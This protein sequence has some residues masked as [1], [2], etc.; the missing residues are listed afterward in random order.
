MKYIYGTAGFRADASLLYAAIIGST[1]AAALRSME[2]EGKTVGVI[3]T[4]SHN[5]VSD[6]GVK[7]IDA[8]GGMLSMAWEE[9]CTNL[10]NVSSK[11]ELDILIKEYLV[12]STCQASVVIGMD[13]R[14]SSPRLSELSK[15]ILDELS[16]S[17]KDYG[18]VTT[19]Q[20]HWIV[21]LINQNSTYSIPSN[22]PPL[23]LYYDSLC[24]AY[25]NIFSSFTVHHRPTLTVDCAN[26][27]GSLPLKE[28]SK[29]LRDCIDLRLTNNDHLAS[30]YLNKDCGADYV[31]TT[32][33]PP[34][35]LLDKMVPNQLYASIDGDADRIIFYFVDKNKKFH[36]LD[37]D[38]ISI[39]LVSFLKILVQK[40][41]L[42]LSI[43]VIQTAY[44]NG[45]STAY[46]KKLGIP[47]ICTSTG[48]K[49]LHHAAKNFDI[50]VYFEANGH[51][52]VLFS[53]GCLHKLHNPST[54]QSNTETAAIDALLQLSQL[55]NQ[56]I[57]DALSDMLAVLSVLG[58][59]LWDATGWLSMYD[60]LPN[61]LVKVKV[62]D[63][64]VFVTTDAERRL[65]KPVGLQEKIDNLVASY[66]DSRSF[67]RA[68]GTEDAVRVYAEAKTPKS[69]AELSA[70]VCGLLQ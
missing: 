69:A 64:S 3:I 13:T 70:K 10:A 51:G 47:I 2:L 25:I 54:E 4:A 16:A 17:Y 62:A 46:L 53:Q 61:K 38:R 35:N 19:P 9:K 65:V 63:R 42:P 27:V 11:S 15:V 45:S 55:I 41:R 22:P 30:K 32:Q 28:L 14:P 39:L 6:N 52:T 36:L 58:S 67:V 43:G 57:G 1:A 68:S 44:A 66:E 34:V 24:N 37:G 21:R 20:L 49:H 48:V 40:S 5:P 7:I 29:R 26:G 12:P 33:S 56:A 31:K 8:D 50:G 23:V 18:F 59:L 60:D